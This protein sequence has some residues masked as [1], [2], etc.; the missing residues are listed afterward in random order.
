M[1]HL[2]HINE[3][4]NWA[5]SNRLGGLDD[6]R[7]PKPIGS[8]YIDSDDLDEMGFFDIDLEGDFDSE[9]LII[10]YDAVDRPLFKYAVEE[11]MDNLDSI[12]IPYEV[13]QDDNHRPYIQ[14]Y[15]YYPENENF[16]YEME[17]WATSNRLGS[18]YMYTEITEKT[19][20]QSLEHGPP[21]RVKIST[22]SRY[23]IGE[24]SNPKD[25]DGTVVGFRDDVS[26]HVRVNWDNGRSNSYRF[27]DLII[28][29]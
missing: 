16:I 19:V 22:T 8:P 21:M 25:V 4:D 23:Y 18:E 3:M 10:T 29:I 28:V 26:H 7:K 27:K 11:D 1:K 20:K 2:K 12:N 17:N 24:G 13:L 6:I 15:P 9:D 5:T 14:I